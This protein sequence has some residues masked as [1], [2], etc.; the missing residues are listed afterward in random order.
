MGLRVGIYGAVL[1]GSSEF[2]SFMVPGS[3]LLE[4][5]KSRGSWGVR[6]SVHGP[7]VFILIP[8]VLRT[9]KKIEKRE[10]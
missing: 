6:D 5:N 9:Y 7:L 4:S 2:G 10:L 8:F 1:E 3:A